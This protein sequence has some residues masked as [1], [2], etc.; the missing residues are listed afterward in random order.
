MIA[1]PA[2]LVNVSPPTAP[3]ATRLAGSTRIPIRVLAVG[4]TVSTTTFGLARP[5]QAR[6]S[7]TVAEL[8]KCTS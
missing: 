2:G 4:H 7:N 1:V 6:L 3:L 8:Q 5:A